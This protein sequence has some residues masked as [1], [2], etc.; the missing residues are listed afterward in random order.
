MHHIHRLSYEI[1][2]GK[3][4]S[5]MYVCH[6]CD[7]RICSNPAHL[8]LGTPKENLVDA[9]MKGRVDGN[10]G[11][12]GE[13]HGM[14]KITEEQAMQILQS[15]E[16]QAEI[17]TRLG[18]S[19]CQVGRIRRGEAWFHLQEDRARRKVVRLR[20]RAVMQHESMVRRASK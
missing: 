20:E 2:K 5:G 18:I 8:F 15:S 19:K 7:N 1:H 17:A 10:G 14:A 13:I 9:A 12:H 16:T 3:I 4:P 11:M 6:A